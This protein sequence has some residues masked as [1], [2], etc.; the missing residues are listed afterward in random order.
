M[1]ENLSAFTHCPWPVEWLIFGIEVAWHEDVLVFHP[2]LLHHGL[3]Y[4]ESGDVTQWLKTQH[5]IS[6]H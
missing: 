4:L 3:N 6:F 2:Q 5:A 1:V